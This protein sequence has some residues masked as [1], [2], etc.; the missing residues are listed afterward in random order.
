MNNFYGD[1]FVELP[2]SLVAPFRNFVEPVHL[3]RNRAL[4]AWR[5]HCVA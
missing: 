1:G 3:V 4:P 5:A 2:A